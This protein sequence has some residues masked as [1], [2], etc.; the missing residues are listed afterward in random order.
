MSTQVNVY[1]AKT[2]LSKLIDRVL[3]GE[4]IVIARAGRPVID[5]VPHVGAPVVLGGL[6]HAIDF[7]QDEFDSADA[8]V[9]AMFDLGSDDA[10]A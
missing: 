2:N 1:D 8:D 4:R 7:D 10:P 3:A 6:K 9:V 5:L